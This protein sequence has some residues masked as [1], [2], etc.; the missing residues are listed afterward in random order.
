[1]T[2]PL[3]VLATGNP[4]KVRELSGL[5]ASLGV[6]LASLADYPATTPVEEDGASSLENARAKARGYALQLQQWVLADDTVLCVDALGGAPGILS[7]RYAGERATMEENRATL[8]A[9]LELVSDHQRTAHFVCH[10]VVA[11]PSGQIAAESRGTCAGRIL[12]EPCAGQYGFGYDS[13][14]Q[15]S[16]YNQTLAE[17]APD[18]TA[19]VGHRGRAV[20][21]LGE[22]MGRMG[23]AARRCPAGTSP[24]EA[25]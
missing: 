3:L 16:G 15:V 20:A 9:D 17:L 14:F 8:L 4:H 23:L 19:R 5:L 13:L 2:I 21:Q 18:I 6:P 12:R 24:A 7:A 1:M 22:R 25:G 11:D 10:L